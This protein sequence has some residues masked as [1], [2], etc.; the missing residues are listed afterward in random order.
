MSSSGAQLVWQED[1][2]AHITEPITTRVGMATNVPRRE[3]R[4]PLRAVL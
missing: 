3:A 4:P 1:A 2:S